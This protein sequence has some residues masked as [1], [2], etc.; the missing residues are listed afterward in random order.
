MLNRSK[1]E[2]RQYIKECLQDDI[3]DKANTLIVDCT[4]SDD[5]KELEYQEK[6]VAALLIEE[7][8]RIYNL[9]G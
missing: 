4:G 8:K 7:V 9:K 5:A 2:Y 1:E 6:D 3:A